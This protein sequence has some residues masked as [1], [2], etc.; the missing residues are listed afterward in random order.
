MGPTSPVPKMSLKVWFSTVT[1]CGS[2]IVRT[3]RRRCPLSEQYVS[4][5]RTGNVG[6]RCASAQELM[7]RTGEFP[8]R[9]RYAMNAD[10]YQPWRTLGDTQM[11]GT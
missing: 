2:V 3:R 11:Y 6:A 4:P 5:G 9:N 10:R 8:R 7:E 1:D